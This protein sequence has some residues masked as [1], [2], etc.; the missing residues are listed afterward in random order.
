MPSAARLPCAPRG[1]A[2]IAA[3][4]ILVTTAVGIVLLAVAMRMYPGGTA[5]DATSVGH[6]FWTNFLCD[7]TNDVAVNGGPNHSGGTL[8]R[9]AMAAFSLALGCFW[10][11]L[12]ESF[13]HH[14]ALAAAVRAFGG[15]SVAGLA[16]V[17]IATGSTHVQAVFAS[18]VPALV[19]GILGLV[20]TVRYS[21]SRALV[22]VACATV[23]AA[24]IDSIFY[25]RS[26]MVHP[27]VVSPALPFFQ[28]IALILMLAW[29][30]GVAVG[31]L[32]ARARSQE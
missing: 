13:R 1:W 20:A 7:L 11:I 23:A 26:Y 27:R 14:R 9:I 10:I 12:P 19:A 5:I 30:G 24:F 2:V 16:V 6:S 31:V 29:M 22:A 17:P 4:A 8:A 28:R 25:A 21:S 3:V 32:R 15:V 18:S